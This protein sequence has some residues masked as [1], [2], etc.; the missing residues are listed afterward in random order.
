[1]PGVE[2]LYGAGQKKGAP[3]HSPG[4]EPVCHI[5]EEDGQRC[6]SVPPQES[7]E[8]SQGP[9]DE[10]G[11]PVFFAAS[12]Q[13]GGCPTELPSGQEGIMVPQESHTVLFLPSLGKIR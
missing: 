3:S 7:S 4:I 11:S 10:S 12:S 6:Q 2:I 9:R 5:A 13:S 1:M 8:P